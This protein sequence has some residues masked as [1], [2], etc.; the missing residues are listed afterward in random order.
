M[1]QQQF[2]QKTRQNP[3]WFL[4][5]VFGDDPWQKQVEILHDLRDHKRVTVRSCHGIGKS[6]LASRAAMWFLFAFQPSVV[7]TTAPTFRQVEEVLWREIRSAYSK[8]KQLNAPGLGGRMGHTKYN[9]ADDWFAMGFSTNDPDFAQGIH[10]QNVLVIPDESSGINRNIFEGIEG[11]LASGNARLLLIGNPTDPTSYFGDSFKSPLFIKHAISALDTPNF[12]NFPTW[13]AFKAST[14]QERDAGITHP[15]LISPQW[16][17]ERLQEWGEDSPMFLARVKGE[18]PAQ[19][20]NSLVQ[21]SWVE[22]ANN[23]YETVVTPTGTESFGVDVARFGGDKTVIYH[24]KGNTAWLEAEYANNDTMEVA[25]R[26]VDLSRQY[27]DATFM[28]D[29]IGVGAGVVDRCKEV[30]MDNVH[31]VNVGGSSGI[32]D[33]VNKRAEYYWRLRDLL[34]HNELA[35]KVDDVTTQQ[36]TSLTF[37]YTSTGKIQI[38]SKEDMKKRGLKSPDRADALMLAFADVQ[39][40]SNFV[41]GAL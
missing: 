4:R 8:A 32:E 25:G 24:R 12:K 2:I 20:D 33:K 13:E 19:A 5:E 31:G 17:Y 39:E 11:I 9:L 34:S 10:N 29:E 16:A 6:W 1:N 22:A 36:L 23:R 27:P 3:T 18:F 35:L 26:I 37:K 30:G 15:Y 14:Q 40:S 28:V 7:L 38:E 41:F 21:L